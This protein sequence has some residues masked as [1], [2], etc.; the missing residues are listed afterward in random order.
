MAE[1]PAWMYP[2]DVDAVSVSASETHERGGVSAE[3]ND[4]ATWTSRLYGRTDRTTNEYLSSSSV[5][6]IAFFKYA[7]LSV[8]SFGV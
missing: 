2:R 6:V 3:L 8:R 4:E 7:T 1:G 5:S